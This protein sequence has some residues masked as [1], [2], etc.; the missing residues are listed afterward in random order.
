MIDPAALVWRDGQ[1][2][3]SAFGDIYHDR[4]G[5]TETE[6]VFLAPAQF[7]TL[8]ETGRPLVVGELGFG[9]GLN[10]AVIALNGGMPVSPGRVRV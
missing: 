8:L 3:S 10:F 4:D 2:Y 6:R 5:V 7:D 1:P 9:T